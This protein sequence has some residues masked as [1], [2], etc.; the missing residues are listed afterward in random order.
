M[1]KDYNKVGAGSV[2]KQKLV[3]QK[4]ETCNPGDARRSIPTAGFQTA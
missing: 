4:K 2:S 1:A 3:E